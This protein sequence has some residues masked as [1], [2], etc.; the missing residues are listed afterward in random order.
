VVVVFVAVVVR[1]IKMG[2]MLYD[3]LRDGGGLVM[4]CYSYLDCNELHGKWS[5]VLYPMASSDYGSGSKNVRC[6]AS[7][8][9][10]QLHS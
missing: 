1:Q 3:F 4:G 5:Q 7:L 8:I 6:C 9:K 10:L 2:N